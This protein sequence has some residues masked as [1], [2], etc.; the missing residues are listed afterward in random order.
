MLWLGSFCEFFFFLFYSTLLKISITLRNHQALTMLETAV[1]NELPTKDLKSVLEK[2]AMKK[3]EVGLSNKREITISE[4]IFRRISQ[5]GIKSVFGVPGDFNLRFL[6][7]IYDVKEL[8][9]IGCCNELNAAYAADA[10]G[11]TSGKMGALVTTYGVGELSAL[12]GIAG[13]YTEFAPLLHLVGTSAL[14]FKRDPRIFNVHHLAGNKY[15]WK[16]SDHY[17]YEKIAN[18]FSVDSASIEDDP[19]E[20]CEMVDRV[21]LNVWRNSRPGYIFLPCDLAEMKVDI[22]RLNI[23]M[24]LDYEFTTPACKIDSYVDKILDMMYKSENM[25]IIADEFI[26]KFRMEDQLHALLE[27]LDG[28]VNLF[29]TIFSKGLLD[30]DDPRFVG[31]YFGKYENPVANIIENS[32]LV[33][34]LGKFDNEMNCG[35]FTFNLEQDKLVEFNPQYMKIGS[36]FDESV[37]MME[38]IPRLVER[39]DKSKI[40]EAVKYEKPKKSYELAQPP[41]IYPLTEVD[42][43]KALNENIRP[44]DVLI[45]ETCSFLFAVPDLKVRNAKVIIQAYWAS[46]GYALPATLGASL[47][48]RDFNLPGRVITVEGD[49]SA[50]MSLQE[51]SSMLRYNID[52][53]ML[54]LNNSGYTIERAIVGPYSSYNDINANWQWG[55]MLKCFGDLKQEKSESFK[56][57]N[58]DE[59]R[60]TLSADH[61]ANG[62]FKLL[63]LILPMFDVPEKLT[64][65]V[66]S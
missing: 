9:F 66:A 44:N 4:Y 28:K 18:N 35:N 62:K 60:K 3:I 59:L 27:K 48:L 15:T 25:S 26:R 46:I 5:L 20:A 61:Y 43:V 30:E 6:E 33:L 32:D 29:S 42:L 16:K 34:H 31:T 51:L 63:E 49:G 21:I 2:K 22:S 55:D 54:I 50:Q 12:N 37:T 47:A 38:I 1:K 53:T 45:V 13:A 39:L 58:P 52:A 41:R 10:Y 7:H 40:T 65:V 36:E 19:E 64:K 57:Q 14:K 56:V 23:P 17:V 24:K 8:N 11:K